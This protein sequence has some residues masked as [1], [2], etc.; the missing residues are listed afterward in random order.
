[1][2]ALVLATL[3][4]A[5]SAWAADMTPPPEIQP[6]AV[7]PLAAPRRL[8]AAKDWAGA[9][10]ALRAQPQAASADWHN[11]MGYTLRKQATPQFA[12]AESQYLEALRIDPGHRGANEYLGELYVMTGELAKARERLVVLEKL[13][14]NGCEQRADLQRAIAAA[15]K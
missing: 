2:R 14:P 4:L 5:T 1:M 8:I 10:A 15:G 13:C 11:L 7:D 12:E 6:A 9:L 3:L